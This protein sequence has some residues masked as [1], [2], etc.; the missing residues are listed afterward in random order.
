MMLNGNVQLADSLI[1][2]KRSTGEFREHPDL[3]DDQGM[4]L[5]YVP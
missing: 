5:Y 3:P 2:R 4:M 1:L